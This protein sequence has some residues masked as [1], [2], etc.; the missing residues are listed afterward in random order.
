MRIALD[1]LSHPAVAKLLQQHLD[2]MYLTSPPESVHALDLDKLR[3]ADIR[4]WTIWHNDSL[5]GCGALKLHS[6]ELAEIKSMRTDAE[7]R[8]KG[9]GAAMLQHIID[10]ARQQGLLSLKLETGSQAFFIPAH[11]LYQRFG[12]E[13]C[14]P[15]ADYTDDPNSK[16]MCLQLAP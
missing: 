7:H 6:A 12:F 10:Y 8:G 2:D 1:D 11:R 4:F 16:F 14:S 15:F 13:F 5:L 3:A 9:V